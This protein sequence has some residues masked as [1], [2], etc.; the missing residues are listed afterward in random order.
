MSGQCGNT[1]SWTRRKMKIRVSNIKPPAVQSEERW[2][3]YEWIMYKH[4]QLDEERGGDV[5]MVII[6]KIRVRLSHAET[7]QWCHGFE[8]F[9]LT[10]S[11]AVTLPFFAMTSVFV[12]MK[13]FYCCS[14][15]S[16]CEQLCIWSKY[17][18]YLISCLLT[19]PVG[20]VHQ[21][22]C[23]Y[24]LRYFEVFFQMGKFRHIW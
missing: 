1:C 20:L 8:R 17:L 3:M 4:Q 6:M 22:L 10:K 2:D 23:S 24:F 19:I 9:T 18:S 5:T 16:L 11:W 7:V 14:M 15:N 21:Y 12:Y 13:A